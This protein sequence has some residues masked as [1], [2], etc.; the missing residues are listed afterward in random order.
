[1]YA[2]APPMQ[3]HFRRMNQARPLRAAVRRRAWAACGRK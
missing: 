2:S 3:A 1:V